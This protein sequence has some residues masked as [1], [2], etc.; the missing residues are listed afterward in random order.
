ML[1]TVAEPLAGHHRLDA[2]RGHLLELAGDTE[3]ARV[4]YRAAAARTTSLPE[5]RY[6]ALRAARLRAATAQPG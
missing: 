6:L 3:G 2:V 5:Q 4:H 1:E